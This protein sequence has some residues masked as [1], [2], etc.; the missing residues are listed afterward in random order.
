MEIR[1]LIE[2][3]EILVNKPDKT[4]EDYRMISQIDL[5]ISALSSCMD[6]CTN[7][8]IKEM[9]IRDA[10]FKN[11]KPSDLPFKMGNLEVD[12]LST[13][14]SEI[15]NKN[16]SV[17]NVQK[18]VDDVRKIDDSNRGVITALR[19]GLRIYGE[20]VG[21][22]I[23]EDSSYSPEELFY[24]DLDD[25]KSIVIAD[26]HAIMVELFMLPTRSFSF[27]FL[28]YE[29]MEELLKTTDPEIIDQ[30]SEMIAKYATLD[31]LESKQYRKVMSRF[32]IK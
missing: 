3:R 32:Q 13:V 14:L 29:H 4:L 30:T 8:I 11:T 25:K 20:Q 6:R 7:I 18:Y 16:A 1:R 12:C 5:S 28:T 23:K 26:R 17:Y 19:N 21:R 22:L 31:E 10:V 27:G 9:G 15:K 24:K 2:Y